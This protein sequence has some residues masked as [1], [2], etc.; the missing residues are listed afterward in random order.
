MTFYL[1][2]KKVKTLTKPNAGSTYKWKK[3]GKSM[4]YGT[5]KVRAKVEFVK[6]AEPTGKT[7]WVQFSRCRPKVNVRPM[8]PG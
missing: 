2:G 8:T 6:G 3:K 5:Y 1:N 7:H 4:K